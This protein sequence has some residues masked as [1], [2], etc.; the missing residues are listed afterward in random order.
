M[1]IRSLLKIKITLKISDVLSS[2]S[3]IN[4]INNFNNLR[5][6]NRPSARLIMTGNS[7]T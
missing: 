7:Q 6:I 5:T 4:Q 2:K 1:Q 3:S